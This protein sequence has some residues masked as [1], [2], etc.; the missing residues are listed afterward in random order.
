MMSDQP[1]ITP[2]MTGDGSTIHRL[3]PERD[4]GLR[5]EDI[6]ARSGNYI[7]SFG[8]PGSGKT[9]F[10]WFLM[11]YLMNVGDFQTKVMVHDTSDGS[12]WEGR[13]I[14]NDWKKLWIER[15]F[16]A[17]TKSGEEDIREV[18]C[19]V[20]PRTGQTRPLDFS[21]LEIS[22]ELLRMVMPQEHN[23]PNLVPTLAAYLSNTKMKFILVLMLHPDVEDND[24][25]FAS[26][27]T[28]LDKNFPNL[29]ERMS[30]AVVISKPDESLER[31]RRYG[32]VN[33]RVNYDEFDEEA[34]EDY[35]NRFCPETYQIWQ[36]WP[37]SSKTLLSPLYLGK[38]KV[39]EGEQRIVDPDHKHIE[40]IFDWIYEQFNGVRL[41][42][43]WWQKLIDRLMFR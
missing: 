18:R 21:F 25:L 28:Y 33:Q 14:I 15:R 42:K 19:R 32:S 35:V 12:E 37:D 2:R 30:L 40:S 27:I 5:V 31:L 1:R 36:N 26:F 24:T 20:T 11:D 39:I 34:V 3:E 41:G 13:R 38:L 17:S 4:P 7:F 22:G 10:Q 16:P 8:Y 23:R 6:K 9:T 43:L 29:R